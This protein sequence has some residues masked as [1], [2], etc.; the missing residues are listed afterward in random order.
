M[1]SETVSFQ[2]P[3]GVGSGVVDSVSLIFSTTETSDF[4]THWQTSW[5]VVGFLS[6]AAIRG[7]V[8]IHLLTRDGENTPARIPPQGVPAWAA[9]RTPA[10]SW[11]LRRQ[12][13]DN[14]CHKINKKCAGRITT[15]K[16]RQ[17]GTWYVRSQSTW[18]TTLHL[19]Y[20]SH[21]SSK[22][23][24]MEYLH[25]SPNKS[26]WQRVRSILR[27]WKILENMLTQHNYQ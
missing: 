5:E 2:R 9:V 20:K 11:N 3:Q 12:H 17:R 10:A 4:A 23:T 22:T 14:N 6:G 7:T 18:R 1:L 26:C 15:L 16:R 8:S 13:S 27:S 19:F 25:C 24:L 21:F